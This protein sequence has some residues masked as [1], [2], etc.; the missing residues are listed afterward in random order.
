[1]E[2]I[3]L[4]KL[5][6]F[7]P[8]KNGAKL[9]L[10]LLFAPFFSFGQNLVPNASFNDIDNCNVGSSFSSIQSVQNWYAG[11]N[12]PDFFNYCFMVPYQAPNTFA[13]FSHP[14]NGSTI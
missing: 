14:L 11:L 8:I 6:N 10:L 13:G 2:I 5:L 3:K 1:M 7:K 12:S 9:Y 4:L